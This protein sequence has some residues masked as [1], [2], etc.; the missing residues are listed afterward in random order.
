MAVFDPL[1]VVI[2]NFP[3]PEVRDHQLTQ[4]RVPL[5]CSGH[6]NYPPWHAN[7]IPAGY[8]SRSS[9]YSLG[10]K[11]RNTQSVIWS[12]HLHRAVRLQRGLCNLVSRV[13]P[14]AC[15]HDLA[16]EPHTPRVWMCDSSLVT[17]DASLVRLTPPLVGVMTTFPS[18]IN[19]CYQ[20][21]TLCLLLCGRKICGLANQ[22]PIMNS[23]SSWK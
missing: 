20:P 19:W 23:P 10:P 9:N 14:P 21:L 2:T 3:H 11:Q 13:Q 6:C 22:V 15:V 7:A 1:R 5:P 16:G 4:A 17:D 12:G 18:P 8:W